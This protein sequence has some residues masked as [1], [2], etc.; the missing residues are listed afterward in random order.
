MFE[1]LYVKEE[2]FRHEQ[3]Q[4]FTRAAFGIIQ[5]VLKVRPEQFA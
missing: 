3:K 2:L 4:A 5:D 1:V